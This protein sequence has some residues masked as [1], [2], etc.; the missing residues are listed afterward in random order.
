[1]PGIELPVALLGG[2][3]LAQVCGAGD[4]QPGE[5]IEKAPEQRFAVGTVGAGIEDMG[6]PEAPGG[7]GRHQQ[8]VGVP[9]AEAEN[10]L[11]F[12][13]GI[14]V[15]PRQGEGPAPALGQIKLPDGGGEC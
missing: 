3:S 11:I 14:G 9:L 15:D 10:T 12:E 1:M 13:Q 2:D 8:L 5:V 6:L 4:T 7:A